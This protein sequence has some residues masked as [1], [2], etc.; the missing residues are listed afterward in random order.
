MN[1]ERKAE[2]HKSIAHLKRM[3]IDVSADSQSDFLIFVKV[4][5]MNKSYKSVWNESTGAWVAVSELATGR[6]KSKRA[7]TAISKAIL[8]QIAVGGMSLAGASAA[9][10]GNPVTSGTGAT[11]NVADGIA[12]GTDAEVDADMGPNAGKTGGIA[13]GDQAYSV[14]SGV[15]VGQGATAGSDS[16]A[17]GTGSSASLGSTAIGLDARAFNKQAVALGESASAGG[18]GS[19]AIG[20]GSTASASSAVALGQNSVADIANTVSVGKAGSERKI[21]NV[22]SGVAS[23]DAVNVGQLTAAGLSFNTTGG[24]TNSFVAYDANLANALITLQGASGTKITNVA[25]G[26]VNAASKDAVNG[27]QLFNV[28]S[29]AA[30]AVGGGSTVGADGKISKPKYTVG[31]VDYSN[32]GDAIN[33]AASMGGT[34]GTGGGTDP[35]ALHYT[36]ANQTSVSLGNGTTAVKVSNVAAGEGHVGQHEDHGTDEGHAERSEHR[37]SERF[38]TVRHGVVGSSGNWWWLNV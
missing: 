35:L 22:A 3:S 4:Y 8:T 28:A 5:S 21:V 15:A 23:T 18:Q 37:R 31:G 17:F 10:A 7:K 9:M 36:D 16:L 29:S 24:V 11:V 30:D 32:V 34:G 25:A 6:S 1:A 19:L 38:A 20:A 13:I 14:G 12:I 26:A 33:K 27:A 2:A